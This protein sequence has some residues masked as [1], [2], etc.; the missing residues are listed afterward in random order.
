M[1]E[2]VK[3]YYGALYC[4][5]F[6]NRELFRRLTG[7]NQTNDGVAAYSKAQAE[8]RTHAKHLTADAAIRHYQLNLWDLV[9]LC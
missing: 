2:L 7:M 9:R 6:F 8:P 5:C 1:M 3:S 4:V